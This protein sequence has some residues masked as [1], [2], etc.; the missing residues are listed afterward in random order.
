MA[1]GFSLDYMD[2]AFELTSAEVAAPFV[3]DSGRMFFPEF[4][5]HVNMLPP[6]LPSMGPPPMFSFPSGDNIELVNL[7]FTALQAGS[8]TLSIHGNGAAINQG[9]VTSFGP[10][11]INGSLDLNVQPVPE[12]AS[13]L[14]FGV[15]SAGLAW[16]SRKKRS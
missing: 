9:L 8:Y 3:N 6:G 4:A 1:F 14:L 11:G 7:G 15:G 12:P 13:M 16:V 5:G 2:T 10:V